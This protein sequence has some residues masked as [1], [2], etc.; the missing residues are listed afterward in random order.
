MLSQSVTGSNPTNAFEYMISKYVDQKGSTAILATKRSAGVTPEV[1][2][3]NPLYTSQVSTLAL[4]H[5]CHQKSKKG[6]SVAHKNNLCPPKN[7]KKKG[8]TVI[9]LYQIF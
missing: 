4:K 6:V 1:N 8:A 5:R 2:L 7:Y 3:R 9:S